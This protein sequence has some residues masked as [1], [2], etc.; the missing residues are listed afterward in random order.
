MNETNWE[1]IGAISAISVIIGVCLVVR[2]ARSK[3][4]NAS[5]E[6]YHYEK[7][8]E[9]YRS[10]DDAELDEVLAR[11]LRDK[12]A[13]SDSVAA[14]RQVMSERSRGST[15]AEEFNSS[16]EPLV[17]ENNKPHLQA[18]VNRSKTDR[19]DSCNDHG[20][21]SGFF[22]FRKMVS[23]FLIQFIYVIGMI[24]ITLYGL[25]YCQ[26]TLESNDEPLADMYFGL[27][28][29]I[30]IGGNLVWRVISEL[31]IMIFN[32]HNILASI[33]KKMG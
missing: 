12:F 33:E 21:V 8:L 6:N 25:Y 24:L 2:F 22:S 32:I 1:N 4:S 14:T 9:R 23:R 27:G 7:F 5:V 18:E 15:P 11:Q 16:Q 17:T 20:I 19:D 26:M 10:M 30:L 29:L 13:D 3:S 28:L 31:L